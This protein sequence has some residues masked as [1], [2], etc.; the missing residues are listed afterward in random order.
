M[1]DLTEGLEARFASDARRAALDLGERSDL[2]LEDKVVVLFDVLVDPLLSADE[3]A[4]LLQAGVT[5]NQAQDALTQ[6]VDRELVERDD[7]TQRPLD[8]EDVV[9]YRKAGVESDTLRLT[10]IESQLSDGR[11]IFQFSVDGRLIRAIARI[12]R[13]DAIQGTGQQ[14]QEI[15]RHVQ[16]IADGIRAGLQVPNA[17]LLV[18]H[19]GNVFRPE[20]VVEDDTPKASD[21]VVDPL[22][23]FAEVYAPRNGTSG[24]AQISRMVELSIP[25]RPAAFDEEKPLLLVDGQQRTAALSLVPLDSHPQVALSVNALVADDDHAKEIFTIANSTQKIATDFS[26][27]LLAAMDAVPPHL[28]KDRVPALVTQLLAIK[29]EE[30][31]FYGIVQVSWYARDGEACSLQH[32]LPRSTAVC[33]KQSLRRGR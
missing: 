15:R 3:V 11:S 6:G 2:S 16:R 14:R 17:L 28:R 32:A 4:A 12:D 27:A 24:P 20:D 13:L 30:S 8:P 9:L 5:S 21:V 29:E 25:Y 10:A 19:E 18:I 31:P 1:A 22:G 33:V 7:D 26:R 23:E